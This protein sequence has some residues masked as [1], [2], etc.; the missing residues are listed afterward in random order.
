MGVSVA[1]GVKVE[2]GVEVKQRR[3]AAGLVGDLERVREPRAKVIAL[4]G[5]EDL[6]LVLKPA[7]C[8]AAHDPLPIDDQRRQA[9]GQR[10][11]MAAGNVHRLPFDFRVRLGTLRTF[12]RPV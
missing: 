12:W 1:V 6:R 5:D 10:V 8:G 4:G 9:A 11:G 3:E 7:E 2:V